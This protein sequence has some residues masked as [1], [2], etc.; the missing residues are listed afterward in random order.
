[1]IVNAHSAEADIRATYE[2]LLAQ[3]DKY[4]D[5]D[6]EDKKG[7]VS[8]P[9]KNDVEALHVF[10][11]LNKPVDFAGRMVYNEDNIPCFNFGKHKGKPVVQVFDEEH[12][13]YGWM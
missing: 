5:V 6:Y 4:K 9:V 11:N 7:V 3:I 8:Q 1:E 12:S 10:T 13:Y 2:V